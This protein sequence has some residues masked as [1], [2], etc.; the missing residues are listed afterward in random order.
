MTI[1]EAK[2]IDIIRISISSKKLIRFWYE[3][4]T[5]NFKDWRIVEPHLVGLTNS[6]CPEIWLSGWFIPTHLQILNNHNEG[7]GNYILKTVKHIE[8]LDSVFKK[9]RPGY[10]CRD[11]RMSIIYSSI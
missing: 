2:L 5:S 11:K 9:P 8:I 4:K 7:W 10:N 6:K 3:D 1:H